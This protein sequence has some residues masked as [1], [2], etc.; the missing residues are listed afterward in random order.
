MFANFVVF[1]MPPLPS[2]SPDEVKIT[3]SSY[4]IYHPSMSPGRTHRSRTSSRAYL[5]RD[6]QQKWV[7][8]VW[9]FMYDVCSVS[10]FACELGGDP[11]DLC[12][13]FASF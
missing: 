12:F 2:G 7:A 4:L 5:K 1:N 10:V 6:K 8:K 11:R 13:M 9:F 3:S